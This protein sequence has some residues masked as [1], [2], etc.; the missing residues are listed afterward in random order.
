[1]D[2]WMNVFYDSMGNRCDNLLPGG[3][4]AI[5]IYGAVSNYLTA[6]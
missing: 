3:A 2:G 5:A 6:A 1:M 4:K